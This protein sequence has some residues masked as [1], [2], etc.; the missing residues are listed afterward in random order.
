MVVVVQPGIEVGLE[1]LD[2]LVEPWERIVG[3]KNSSNTVPLK[4]STKPLVRGD[5]TG[6]RCLART[7]GFCGVMPQRFR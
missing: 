3:R 5:G 6:A 2:A 4:R 7:N 1:R